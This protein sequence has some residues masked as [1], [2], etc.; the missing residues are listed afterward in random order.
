M[1]V[2][3]TQLMAR[4]KQ[5]METSWLNLKQAAVHTPCSKFKGRRPCSKLKMRMPCLKQTPADEADV[6]AFDSGTPSH[7]RTILFFK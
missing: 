1:K 5:S 2:M 4:M 7:A 6:V 3:A